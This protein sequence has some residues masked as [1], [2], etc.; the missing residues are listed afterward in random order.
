M[1]AL[2]TQKSKPNV[3]AA[4]KSILGSSGNLPTPQTAVTEWHF[5]SESPLRITLPSSA[6]DRD[7]IIITNSLTTSNYK[8]IFFNDYLDTT[9]RIEVW[10]D[11]KYEFIYIKDKMHWTLVSQP[12]RNHK[13]DSSILYSNIA[14]YYNPITEVNITNETAVSN[15]AIR[16]GGSAPGNKVI[17]RNNSI[18]PFIIKNPDLVY[19]RT[20]LPN[21]TIRFERTTKGWEVITN[22]VD[23]LLINSPKVNELLGESAAKI[24]L[25][26]S[27]NLANTVAEN[28]NANVYFRAAGFMTADSGKSEISG[29]TIIGSLE[30][31]TAELARIKADGVLYQ[32]AE[33]RNLCGVANQSYVSDLKSSITAVQ[34]YTCPLFVAPH[35][36]GHT[37]GLAHHDAIIDT[38]TLTR[39]KYGK[40]MEL[41]FIQ[42]IMY[43]TVSAISSI[44]YYSS[45]SL[46][47]PTFGLRLGEPQTADSVRR[48]NETAYETST[49]SDRRK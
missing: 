16:L 33:N 38:E 26:E 15:T 34:Q 27:M 20:V 22:T 32:G 1:W 42:T 40:D 19:S 11:F 30:S 5:D 7:R 10:P 21:E 9:A 13:I 24:R 46:Y 25:L 23:L 36:L 14:F 43:A 28:S 47:E 17:V 37:L 49:I 8:P 44:P 45:P 12:K 31:V 35:E 48:I 18:R 39:K 41:P 6:K 4:K 2:D 3:L 29:S